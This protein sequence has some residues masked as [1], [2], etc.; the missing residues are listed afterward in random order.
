MNSRERV[1]AALTFTGPDR[2]PI[3]HRTLPGAFRVHGPA[4]RALYARFPSDVLLSPTADAPFA[5]QRRVTE[6]SRGSELVDE[7]GCAWRNTTDD[8]LGQVVGHPLADLGRLD[9]YQWPDPLSGMEGVEELRSVKRADGLQHYLIAAAGSIMHQIT[10][11]RGFENA[12]LDLAEEREEVFFLRD[13]IGDFVTKRIEVLCAAGAD[14][15]LIEDDWGTQ[16]SLMINPNVW[17]RVFKPTYKKLVEA[18]HAGGAYAHLHSD[19]YIMSIIPDLIEMGWDEI[20]PQVWVMDV[21]KLGQQ[22]AG[23]VCFRA[24]LDRQRILPWG[25]PAE[26]VE[27]VRQTYAAF[28][29]PD[30]GYI[31]YGQ[32]GPDVP[33]ANVEAMLRTFG[34]V[35]VPQAGE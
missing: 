25:T 14:G 24:D 26:V 12:L 34:E 35:H 6:R 31:G 2:V 28:G 15:I 5:F 1:I 8:Y 11:L 29:H 27:H 30:G 21:R 13:R 3:M 20:N 23:R 9:G 32:I 17:R 16:K 22:F 18:I 7:W 4:L 19:G 33:L 10:F